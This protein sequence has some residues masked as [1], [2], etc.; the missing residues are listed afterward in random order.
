MS[1]VSYVRYWAD[2]ASGYCWVQWSGNEIELKLVD[3]YLKSTSSGSE[4]DLKV[5]IGESEANT[6]AK[7]GEIHCMQSGRLCLPRLANGDLDWAWT[8]VT[9]ELIFG[10]ETASYSHIRSLFKPNPQQ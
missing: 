4:L 2:G 1:G 10:D 3:E 9:D 5:S 8:Q 6:L 7:H